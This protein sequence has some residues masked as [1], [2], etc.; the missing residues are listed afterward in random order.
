MGRPVSVNGRRLARPPAPALAWPR[1]ILVEYGPST[2]TALGGTEYDVYIGDRLVGAV[3]GTPTVGRSGRR[4]G[5]P[6]WTISA[7]HL[8]PGAVRG[9]HRVRRNTRTEATAELVTAYLASEEAPRRQ[10]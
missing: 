10:W 9:L 6:C 8:P 5:A 2:T 4:T 1:Q 3:R 7:R